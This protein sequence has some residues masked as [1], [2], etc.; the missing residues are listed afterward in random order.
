MGWQMCTIWV[1]SCSGGC[2]LTLL[3][4]RFF[5]ATCRRVFLFIVKLTWCFVSFCL[6]GV[7][8]NVQGSNWQQ[9]KC[10]L[11]LTYLM[12]RKNKKPSADR[13]SSD[14]QLSE[15][16]RNFKRQLVMGFEQ[17][18][19]KSWL[20]EMN[21]GNQLLIGW[22]PPESMDLHSVGHTIHNFALEPNL[23]QEPEFPSL[24]STL[25]LEISD[26]HIVP[27]SFR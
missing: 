26:T 5:P 14:C 25:A 21:K 7:L 20:F 1:P 16:M 15:I 4:E 23:C 3:L 12:G 11:L 19:S 27:F 8:M 2:A 24:V 17:S 9:Q 6:F 10:L 22:G 13:K 18:G